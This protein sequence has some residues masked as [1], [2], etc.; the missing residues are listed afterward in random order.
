MAQGGR[1]R[2][3]QQARDSHSPHVNE[4]KNKEGAVDSS[5]WWLPPTEMK[6]PLLLW[7]SEND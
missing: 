5:R 3:R 7:D 2:Y 1:Q 6:A 4:R